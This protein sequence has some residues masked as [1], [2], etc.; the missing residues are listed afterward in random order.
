MKLPRPARCRSVRTRSDLHYPFDGHRPASNITCCRAAYAVPATAQTR[1]ASRSPP[2]VRRSTNSST[3]SDV[4][5]W[6]LLV[7]AVTKLRTEVA[8]RTAAHHD[9]SPHMP[10]IGRR[11]LRP[12]RDSVAGHDQL[13]GPHSASTN[14]VGRL[15]E[16]HRLQARSIARRGCPIAATGNTHS[17]RIAG[18]P[19]RVFA[20]RRTIAPELPPSC[21]DVAVDEGVTTT[22]VSTTT[23][24]QKSTARSAEIRSNTGGEE[25]AQKRIDSDESDRTWPITPGPLADPCSVFVSKHFAATRANF[26]T[27]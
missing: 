5:P 13:R 20:T 19:R 23:R 7:P 25:T 10:S 12:F 14:R 8:P 9:D 17:R 21:F 6:P 4:V 26:A 2:R 22:Q 16:R 27:C 24:A 1:H 18:S 3:S 11:A 15:R